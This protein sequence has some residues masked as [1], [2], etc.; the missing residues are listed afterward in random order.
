MRKLYILI[1]C[2]VVVACQKE[3]AEDPCTNASLIRKVKSENLEIQDVTYNE[4]CQ[5]KESVE[6]FFYKKYTYD[7][8][9]L[10]KLESAMSFDAASCFMQP[11]S[12]GETFSDPR[13]AK[14]MQYYSFEYDNGKLSKKSNYFNNSGNFKLVSYQLYHYEDSR[15]DKIENFNPNE[16]L[17]SYNTYLYDDKGNVT[18]NDYYLAVNN[19]SPTL[20]MSFIYILDNKLNPYSVFACEGTPGLFTNLNNITQEKQ[21]HY[22]MGVPTEQLIN[23]NFEYNDLGYPVKSNNNSFIYG[24]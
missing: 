13:K 4:S 5:V 19:A 7:A 15:I 12:D 2:L 17:T 10:V 3:N 23:T 22:N 20:S 24:N 16:Q 6:R 1:G 18:R 21:V 9:N 8:G 14:V 11:G